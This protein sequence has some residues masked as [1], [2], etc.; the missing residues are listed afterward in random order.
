MPRDTTVRTRVIEYLAM[1]GPIEDRSGRATSRLK[2]AVG[3]SGGD[4]GFIRIV[5]LMAESGEIEREVKGKRTYRIAAAPGTPVP[6]RPTFP[7]PATASS[8]GAASFGTPVTDGAPLGDGQLDYDELASS[9]L[10]RV[11]QVLSDSESRAGGGEQASWARRRIDQLEA[12]VVS[13]QR[14]AARA[15]AETEAVKEE[16]DALKSQLEAASH[17]LE[18]LTERLGTPARP[19]PRAADRLDSEEQALLYRLRGPRREK[20]TRAG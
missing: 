4:A 6:A 9:L 10:A 3:Y 8:D 13:L 19:T 5:S 14:D 16:R 11:A 17:N 7:P 18:L 15:K 12:R 1:Q 20:P 2:D